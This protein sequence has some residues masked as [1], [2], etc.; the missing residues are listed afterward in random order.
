MDGGGW[1]M[2]Y[3]YVYGWLSVF[4]LLADLFARLL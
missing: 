3:N 2:G 4:L 1:L